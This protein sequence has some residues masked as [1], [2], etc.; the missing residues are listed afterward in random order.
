MDILVDDAVDQKQPIL[1]VGEIHSALRI[2][3]RHERRGSVPF[4]VVQLPS[5]P[6]SLPTTFCHTS[7]IIIVKHTF[8]TDPLAYPDGFSSGVL[9]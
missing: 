8:N 2:T 3:I 5:S 1:L 6:L 7:Q 9:M 4:V